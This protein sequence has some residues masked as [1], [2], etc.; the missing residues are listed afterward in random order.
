MND[1]DSGVEGTPKFLFN[2]Y[3][4]MLNT[5]EGCDVFRG[6]QNQNMYE[7]MRRWQEIPINVSSTVRHSGENDNG[8]YGLC[9][10]VIVTK[11]N[12]NMHCLSVFVCLSSQFDENREA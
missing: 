10:V 4:I 8:K 7:H 5:K 1:T 12:V 2:I 6:G 11:I 3:N 9:L